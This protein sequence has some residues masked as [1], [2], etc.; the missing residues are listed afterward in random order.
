MKYLVLLFSLVSLSVLG[1]DVTVYNNINITDT[2]NSKAVAYATKSLQ[3]DFDLKFGTTKSSRDSIMVVLD[4]DEALDGFDKYKIETAPGNITFTGS[5]E[6]GLI[7]AIYTFSEEVLGIDPFVYFTDIV[8]ETEE[9]IQIPAGTTVSKPYTFT[10]R[11]M[12]LNDEDLLSGFQMEKVEYGFNLDFMQKLYETM[13]RLKMT[14]IIPSTHVLSDEPHLKLASDMGLTIAQHHVE[15]VG[16]TPMFWP[17]NVPYSWSTHKADFVKFWRTA[18]ERQKGKHVIWT[19]NFRG[20]TDRSFWTDDPNFSDDSPDEDKAAVIN[21]VIQTQ[22]DLIREVTGNKNPL[23]CGYLWGELNNLYK[24]GLIKYPDNTMLLFADNGVGVFREGTWEAAAKTALPKGVYQHVSMHN[25]RTHIRINS[26]H[27]D[28]FHREITKAVDYGMTNMIVLNVGNFKEKIFGIQQMVNYMNDFDSYRP[29]QDGSYYFGLYVMDKFNS[30]SK[31]I[32]Q[33]YKDFFENQ[34]DSGRP[35]RK[36]GDEWYSY[37]LERTLNAAYTKDLGYFEKNNYGPALDRAEEKWAVSVQRALDAKGKLSGSLQNFYNVDLVLPAQKM[38]HLNAMA[39]AFTQSIQYY[40][41]GKYHEAQLSAYAALK[42]QEE[43]LKVE[44]EIENSGSGKFRGWYRWDQTAYTKEVK[45]YLE[46][47]LAI[48]KDLKF[49][50]LP[51]DYRNSKTQSIQ[52]KFQPWFDSEYQE[53][54]IY[55]ENAE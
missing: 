41:D 4:I 18:I 17:K 2:S 44:K 15:P 5:D 39:S 1:Q 31:E 27:P 33:S 32:I 30:S 23:V 24:K 36:L 13:L 51:Y 14:G 3:N 8:P 11:I 55:M 46:N 48:L 26:I 12:F 28:I 42:H 53:E 34:I 54:L 43:A 47:Y 22:Y 21:E 10:H 29:Y 7:H 49:F 52:Y 50:N 16:S 9:S 37:Y 38:F 19:L 6:L 20:L 25:R 45:T 40:L 35:E